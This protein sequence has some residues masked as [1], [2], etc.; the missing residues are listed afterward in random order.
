ML[1][2]VSTVQVARLRYAD[3]LKLEKQ[4]KDIAWL[5][6]ENKLT[7]SIASCRV[8]RHI[9]F[10]KEVVRYVEVKMEATNPEGHRIS[11]YLANRYP[12][13]YRVAMYV[14]RPGKVVVSI[15]G[16]VAY[17]FEML[18]SLKEG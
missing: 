13:P 17:C 10:F 9:T 4:V 5:A 6:V 14:H 1:Q 7:L 3:R 16:G 2:G 11:I 12:L 18:A 8:K 15:H